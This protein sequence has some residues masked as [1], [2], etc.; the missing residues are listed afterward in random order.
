MS[1]KSR[2]SP[3]AGQPGANARGVAHLYIEGEHPHIAAELR[4]AVDDGSTYNPIVSQAQRRAMYAAQSGHSNI[5]IPKSVA[6]DFIA[7][8]PASKHLPERKGKKRHA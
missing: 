4:R 2:V 8:G 1:P 3:S 7:A 5:G 6:Q